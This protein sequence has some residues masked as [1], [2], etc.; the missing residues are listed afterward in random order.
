MIPVQGLNRFFFISMG[1]MILFV[2]LVIR[3]FWVQVIEGTRYREIGQKQY[4]ER[5]VV[6]ANRGVIYDRS[7]VPLVTNQIQYSFGVDPYMTSPEEAPLI[8]RRFSKVFGKSYSG[9]LAKIRQKTNFVWLE[10]GVSP[11]QRDRL[12]LQNF[13]SVVEVKEPTRLYRYNERAGQLLGFT[14]IDNKGI[15]GLELFHDSH[16]RGRDGF[17]VMQRDGRGRRVP[18]PDYARQD[19]V[20][21]KSVELTVDVVTQSIVDEELIQGVKSA[22]GTGGVAIF[23]VPQ[24][25]E[26][27]AMSHYP[28]INPNRPEK[29]DMKD[30]RLRA[31]TDVFEPGS[32]FKVVTA[33]AAY[34]YG[35][36]RSS[37][38]LNAENGTWLYKGEKVI[39]HERLGRI[40]FKEA[41]IHSSNVGMAKT[42]LMLGEERFYKIARNFGF[43]METGIDLP[44]EIAGTLKQPLEWSGISLPWMSFGYEVLVTPV[45]MLNAYAAVAN[46]GRLMRPFVVRKI[47]GPDGTVVLEN[48]PSAIRQVISASTVDTLVPALSAVV[49]EGTAK[50]A[51]IKPLSI[52]GK[53]G[54][55]KKVSSTGQYEKS[56]M[57][58]FVGFFPAER[59]ILAGIVILDSPSKGYYGGAVSAPIFGRIAQRI[60]GSS[61]WL[62]QTPVL[63]AAGADT[64]KG[65]RLVPD[66]KYKSVSSAQVLLADQ[67]WDVE[68]IGNGKW[69]I[70]QTPAADS[71]VDEDETLYLK[72][73][74]AESRSLPAVAGI[75]LREAVGKLQTHGYNVRVAGSG[76]V[77]RATPAKSDRKM[78]TLTGKSAPSPGGAQ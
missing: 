51:D 18:S 21:G 49:S 53:T 52:A 69:I 27:V 11:D 12:A 50:L 58:S 3:L 2:I 45:Q 70:G 31:V 23:M 74:T 7:G 75:P 36:R 9:Y 4:Q 63:L 66:V 77:Q 39:D 56:Y 28:P 67:G 65:R 40:T 41:I 16:I 17:V 33:A 1:L 13:N 24:T 32:T 8:A 76:A 48:R 72:T 42:G 25:G 43:G 47:T 20:N 29:I 59:P 54:T 14:N 64:L 61:K 22:G 71:L 68:L 62:D 10:R 44:G 30:A 35:I 46:R 38:W 19:P 6:K 26:I 60:I 34:E 15:S 5:F 78:V 37:D 73:G 55:A 57:A